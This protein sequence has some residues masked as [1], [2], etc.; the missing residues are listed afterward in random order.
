MT[1]S[2]QDI[3]RKEFI[4][5]LTQ[6][7]SP[8]RRS[9]RTAEGDRAA[10][11]EYWV[12]SRRTGVNIL[13]APGEVRAS[14]QD[15]A[16]RELNTRI[17]RNIID[18]LRTATQHSG[19]ATRDCVALVMFGLAALGNNSVPLDGNISAVITPAYLAHLMQ[20][21][22]FASAEFVGDVPF[23]SA[24]TVYRWAGVNFIVHPNLPGR[25]TGEEKCFMYHKDAV[26]HTWAI[27]A[28]GTTI[29]VTD[30]DGKAYPSRMG[31][32]YS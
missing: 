27:G 11:T 32:D 12:G 23:S 18:V 30:V 3:Y 31:L 21:K 10:L 17:N 25:G 6:G 29:G 14:I 7:Q 2:I 8:L 19:P 5:R 20:T 1:D 26:C 16:V 28:V 13:T 24:L 22:E 9:V 4:D 15:G